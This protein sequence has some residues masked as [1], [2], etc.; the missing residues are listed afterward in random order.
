MRTWRVVTRFGREVGLFVGKDESD[1]LAL[2]YDSGKVPRGQKGLRVL[3]HIAGRGPIVTLSAAVLCVLDLATPGAEPGDRRGPAE[4]EVARVLV[5]AAE[6]ELEA[7]LKAPLTAALA[8]RGKVVHGPSLF[9]H[10]GEQE[11]AVIKMVN[12][13]HER[14]RLYVVAETPSLRDAIESEVRSVAQRCVQKWN[15]EVA[16]AGRNEIKRLGLL[17]KPREELANAAV[18]VE[19]LMKP[20]QIEHG[21][22]MVNW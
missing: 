17:G 1:A 11:A 19:L 18:M 3:P 22:A 12:G 9:D 16:E 5:V 10:R 15:T 4:Q 20:P 13:E 14:L 8:L 21:R 7:R 6:P 2:A